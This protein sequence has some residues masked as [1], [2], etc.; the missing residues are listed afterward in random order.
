M[1]RGRNPFDELAEQYD[2]WFDAE[3]GRSIYAWEIDCL[4]S[5]MPSITESMH[6]ADVTQKPRRGVVPGAGFVAVAFAP[7][8]QPL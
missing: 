4:R 1:T 2:A 7:S 6:S 3:P 8:P 5:V